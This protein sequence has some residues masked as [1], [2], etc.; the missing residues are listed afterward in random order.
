MEE[1][2]KQLIK[3]VVKEAMEE[4]SLVQPQPDE[5]SNKKYAGLP[6]VLTAGM[7]SKFLNLSQRRVYEL[8]DLNPNHGGIKC[9]RIG[10]SKR[11]L[12]TD[13]ILWIESGKGAA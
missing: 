4:M 8:M 3:S 6:D 1:L 5:L 7:I 9:L 10:R 13:L 11:V 12:K 2:L